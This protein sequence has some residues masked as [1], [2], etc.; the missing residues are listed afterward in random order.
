MKNIVR[1]ACMLMAV[2]ATYCLIFESFILL[3]NGL[4][5]PAKFTISFINHVV[6]LTVGIMGLKYRDDAEKQK[7]LAGISAMQT[8]FCLFAV[9]VR[10]TLWITLKSVGISEWLSIACSIFLLVYYIKGAVRS[11]KENLT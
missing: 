7:M 2:I 6:M 4:A 10:N 5:G 9:F 8:A 1:Y 3:C 11:K